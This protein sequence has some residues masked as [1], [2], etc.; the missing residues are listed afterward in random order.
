M[1]FSVSDLR[2]NTIWQLYRIRDRI[3]LDPEYQR[4]SDIW[5]LDKRQL[6]VDTILNNFD[7]P[8]LYFHKFLK[9][10]KTTE[11]IF[12]YAII[13]GKQRLE[14][15][16]NFIGGNIALPDEFEFINDRRVKLGGMKYQELGREYPNI[17]ADFDGFSLSVIC[18]ETDEIELIE[19]LF[20]RL[21][22]A[23]TL[24]APEKRNAFPG[25]VPAAIRK[26]S[27]ESF[28]NEALPFPNTRYRHLD[29]C[30]K[31]L[32]AEFQ[33][34]VVDTKKVYLDEF[35]RSFEDRPRRSKP[36]FLK[37]AQDS[38]GRMRN[39]F[40]DNDVLLRQVGMIMV[41]YHLFRIA[42]NEGWVGNITRRKLLKFD[43]QRR[44]N[45]QEAEVDLVEADYDLIEFDRLSQSPNDSYALRFRLRVMLRYVF[46]QSVQS[47]DL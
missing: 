27:K 2:N 33:D 46:G 32:F 4:L 39:V 12:D 35:V 25:P 29:L 11:G 37:T 17:K 6:L 14:A 23:A 45:R 24:T 7:M 42:N 18:I 13:D 5:T 44:K 20:T 47:D 22:E 36:R 43:K 9:P 19:D 38:V 41:Y 1:K 15:I 3:Q 8:K 30:V 34:K 21:N 40:T 26:L 10:L 16:W 28:F 31:F